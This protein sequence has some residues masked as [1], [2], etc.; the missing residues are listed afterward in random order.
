MLERCEAPVVCTASCDEHALGERGQQEAPLTLGCGH[1]SAPIHA[2][3]GNIVGLDECHL[4]LVDTKVVADEIWAVVLRDVHTDHELTLLFRRAKRGTE[5]SLGPV[6]GI[7]A[8]AR[9]QLADPLD[10]GK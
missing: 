8:H 5:E 7:S 4:Q 3:Q 10:Q 2:H 6:R 9:G 1:E